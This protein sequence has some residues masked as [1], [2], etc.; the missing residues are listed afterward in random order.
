M[1]GISIGKFFGSYV[2]ENDAENNIEALGLS[3]TWCFKILYVHE[4][5]VLD[6]EIHIEFVS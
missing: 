1:L 4:L 2:Y 6:G 3:G 5:R